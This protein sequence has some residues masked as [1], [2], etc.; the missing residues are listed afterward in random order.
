MMTRLGGSVDDPDRVTVGGGVT[1]RVP[2][3]T[4]LTLARDLALALGFFDQ[5]VTRARSM[6]Q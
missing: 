6:M 2:G 1:S 5:R 4:N 3:T